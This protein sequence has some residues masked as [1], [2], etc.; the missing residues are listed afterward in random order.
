MKQ[1]EY[2]VE[3][4]PGIRSQLRPICKKRKISQTDLEAFLLSETD[5]YI[6]CHQK[7]WARVERSCYIVPFDEAITLLLRRQQDRWLI[8]DISWDPKKEARRDAG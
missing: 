1:N 5:F 6:A 3:I 4:A 2:R 8:I 7:A